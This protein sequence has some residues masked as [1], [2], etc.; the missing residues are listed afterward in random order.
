MKVVGLEVLPSDACMLAAIC[1][2]ICGSVCACAVLFLLVH[3][4]LTFVFNSVIHNYHL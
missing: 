2:I 3:L 4:L 1:C